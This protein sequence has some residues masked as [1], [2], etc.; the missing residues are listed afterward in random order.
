MC[1][2]PREKPTIEGVIVSAE[3][4]ELHLK[5]GE[6]TLKSS[7]T[8]DAIM[9]EM[10]L[11]FSKV[12]PQLELLSK[13]TLSVDLEKLLESCIG[14][15]ALTPEGVVLRADTGA[16]KD[17]ENIL[18]QLVRAKLSFTTGS[19]ERD[20]MMSDEIASSIDGKSG[21]VAGRLSELVS[22]GLVERVGKGEYRITT[23]G[24][25]CFMD[26]IVP[27]LKQQVSGDS[28]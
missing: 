26:R 22:K 24:I 20:T 12:F 7:G 18:V 19:R 6:H 9:R 2:D 14:I 21:P 28:P 5:F 10:L 16:L 13:L 25:E 3:K 8:P 1:K 15:L 17:Q 27:T 11:F 23:L 4:V